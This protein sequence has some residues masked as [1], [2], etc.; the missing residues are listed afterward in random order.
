MSDVCSSPGSL[1]VYLFVEIS[2]ENAKN[3]EFSEGKYRI[4]G[5][6]KRFSN[7]EVSEENKTDPEISERKILAKIFWQNATPRKVE[8]NYGK[9][10]LGK[11]LRMMA[12]IFT[13]G[14]MANPVIRQTCNTSPQCSVYKRL[15][16]SV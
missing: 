11:M 6:R 14:K 5:A 1:C 10:G 7:P 8:K 3:P 15:Y 12:K 16:R 4:I 13:L 9:N 2:E